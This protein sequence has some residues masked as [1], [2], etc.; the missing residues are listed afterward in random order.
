M[1]IFL[2]IR[3]RVPPLPPTRAQHP[4]RD[5][6]YGTLIETD[7][8]AQEPHGSVVRP[9]PPTAAYN[10]QPIMTIV[11][12]ACFLLPCVVSALAYEDETA[13][14]PNEFKK[15]RQDTPPKVWPSGDEVWS[16]SS[17]D[18]TWYILRFT[19][20]G[21]PRH[22]LNARRRLQVHR[23]AC[24]GAWAATAPT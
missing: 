12:Q 15:W 4:N 2:D 3:L 6:P 19:R 16:S 20:H 7:L 13:T 17:A 23:E 18:K 1:R 5:R 9:L 14:R 22:T 8:K 10:N 11:R 24:V 21:N